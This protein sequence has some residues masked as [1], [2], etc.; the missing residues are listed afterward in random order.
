M[1]HSIEFRLTT[2]VQSQLCTKNQKT[3]KFCPLAL[4]FHLAPY[5]IFIAVLISTYS[6][7]MVLVT[8]Y[9]QYFHVSATL[10]WSIVD[11]IAFLFIQ[12]VFRKTKRIY[13]SIPIIF[14]SPNSFVACLSLIKI[15][16]SR[17]RSRQFFSCWSSN[18]Y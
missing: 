1:A 2:I 9:K 4:I 8:Q 10:N 7:R 14:F 6:E 16:F 12:S 3:Q 5:L 13:L 18:Q 15:I 17:F 11:S